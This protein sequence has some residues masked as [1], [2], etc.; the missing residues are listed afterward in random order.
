MSPLLRHLDMAPPDA[1]YPV[2]VQVSVTGAEPVARVA[3]LP[4]T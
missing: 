1:V 2:E 4:L 3:R